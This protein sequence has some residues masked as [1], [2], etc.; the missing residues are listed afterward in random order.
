MRDDGTVKVLDFGLAKVADPGAVE[1][2]ATVR[3]HAASP[4]I[5]TPAMTAAGIILGTAAYMSPEQ[6]KGKP[7]DKRSDIWA[8]GCVFYEM[9][10]GRRP[11]AGDGVAEVLASVLTNEPDWQALPSNVPPPLRTLL[12]RCL[13]KDR[14]DRVADISTATFV[15]D[16]VASLVVPPGAASTVQPPRRASRRRIAAAERRR[17]DGRRPCWRAGVGRYAPGTTARHTVCAVTNRRGPLVD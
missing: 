16:N 12:Q 2:A 17:R 8:F 11:F 6:A 1:D 3:G 7:A 5:T 14:R 4:T 10:T 13:V 15:L 9:L